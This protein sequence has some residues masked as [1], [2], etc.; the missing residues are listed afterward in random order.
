MHS[1]LNLWYQGVL[2]LVKVLNANERAPREEGA[3]FHGVTYPT[4]SFKVKLVCPVHFTETLQP[5][6]AGGKQRKTSRS[7][8]SAAP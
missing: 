8:K 1:A 3:N 4:A 5:R 6:N 2:E 7:I